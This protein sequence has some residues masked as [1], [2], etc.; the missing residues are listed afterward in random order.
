MC[1]RIIYGLWEPNYLDKDLAPLE[2]NQL[3]KVT[4]NH[5]RRLERRW[6]EDLGTIS[7]HEG[8]DLQKN[9]IMRLTG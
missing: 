4:I 8:E 2:E 1:G 5:T 7:L 6:Q 3:R 9:Y